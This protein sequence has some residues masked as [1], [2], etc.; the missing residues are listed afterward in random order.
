MKN[1]GLSISQWRTCPH[2][3]WAFALDDNLV[4]LNII[5]RKT[6]ARLKHVGKVPQ[7]KGILKSTVSGTANSVAHSLRITPDILSGPHVLFYIGGS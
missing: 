6:F 7:Y 1:A 5:H 4:L 2:A 3:I